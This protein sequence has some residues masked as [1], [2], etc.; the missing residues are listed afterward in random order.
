MTT[1]FVSSGV[2]SSGI[3][4]TSGN[5]LEVLSG[6]TADFTTISSGGSEKVDAGG[7]ASGTVVSNGGVDFI[8]SGGT[9]SGT[10]VSSG[11]SEF[12]FAGGTTFSTTVDSGG[13]EY[14]GS[15]NAFPGGTAISV[16]VNSGG[17]LW[18]DGGVVSSASINSGGTMDVLRGSFSHVTDNGSINFGGF[19]HI[20]PFDYNLSGFSGSGVVDISSATLLLS[21][22][23]S[24]TST[25][26]F[27]I[28][29]GG[30]LELTSAGAANG[31]P[32][33]FTGVN[34]AMR[35]DGTSMPTD[36]IS[37]FTP[38][39]R[40]IALRNVSFSSGATAQVIS[41]NVLQISAGGSA[42]N[43][44]LDPS[45]NYSGLSLQVIPDISGGIEVAIGQIATVSSGAGVSNNDDQLW[46][47][48]G[49]FRQR[50]KRDDCSR[51][52]PDRLLRWHRQRNIDQR[53]RRHSIR[54]GQRCNHQQWRQTAGA[55]WWNGIWCDRKYRRPFEPLFRRD[56]RLG[57]VGG[58]YQCR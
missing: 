46:E 41:G 47:F 5:V 13:T 58:K 42:Y 2:T 56:V 28:G 57:L 50:E 21:L 52:R 18:L 39:A 20:A 34:A 9:A 31:L 25:G 1:T 30:V 4:V 40:W 55:G 29:N 6:G 35:I 12:V 36:V 26:E 23:S 45:L 49:Y 7:L 48:R 54:L 14:V 27:T 37:G 38:G 24:S 16:T 19:N 33:D 3:Q 53:R 51:R 8:S 11:G 22:T 43:L 17:V 15:T 10:T 32:V 44:Q